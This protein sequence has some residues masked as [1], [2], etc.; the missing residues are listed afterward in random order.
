MNAIAVLA[1]NYSKELIDFYGSISRDNYDVYFFID[2][3]SEKIIINNPTYIIQIFDSLCEKYGYHSFNSLI[4]KNK[5]GSL[6]VSAWDKAIFYFCKLNQSYNQIWFVEDDVFVPDINIFPSIDQDFPGEDILSGKRVLNTSGDLEGWS[7]WGKI[8]SSNLP[9]PWAK[10]MV[11][12][13][14]LSQKLLGILGNYVEKNPQSNKFIEFIF[15]TLALHHHLEVKEIDNF[16]GIWWR[17]DWKKEDLNMK[18]LYHPV[19]LI[20]QQIEFRNY[21]TNLKEN[22]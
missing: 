16:R 7:W 10:S 18:T 5:N 9:L 20:A 6:T 2:D 14:R 17:K 15:H 1:K 8:P 3:N 19:K 11:C 21:L 4:D 13:V 12:A 22:Q